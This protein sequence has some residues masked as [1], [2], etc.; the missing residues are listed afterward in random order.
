VLLR[1]VLTVSPRELS[2]IAN[3]RLDCAR[4]SRVLKSRELS[5]YVKNGFPR[6]QGW[7]GGPSTFLILEIL[8]DVQPLS[9]YRRGACEIGVHHGLFFIGMHVLC[10]LDAKSLG[11]DLFAIQ[12]LNVDNSGS[13]SRKILKKTFRNLSRPLRMHGIQVC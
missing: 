6:I 7:C 10:G 4:V 2:A 8:T 9:C 13:G 1:R 5:Y 11:I 3:R 12:H